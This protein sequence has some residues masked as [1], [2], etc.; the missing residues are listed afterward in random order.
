MAEIQGVTSDATNVNFQ[1]QSGEMESEGFEIQATA[2]IVDGLSLVASYTYL[3]LTFLEGDNEGNL[4]TGIPRHQFSLWG[5]YEAVSGPLDGLGFGLGARFLGATEGNGANTQPENG[6]RILID[7][8]ASYDFGAADQRLEG[9]RA[10]VNVNNLFDKRDALCNNGCFYR[11][12][13]RQVI[14]SLRYRF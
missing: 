7:A 8:S 4:V 10:Q 12:Q 13:G 11:E 14:G 9:V 2:S 3:D 6:A 5:N 1:V